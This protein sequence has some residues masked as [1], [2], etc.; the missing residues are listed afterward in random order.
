LS[1]D[2]GNT[3]QSMNVSQTDTVGIVGGKLTLSCML[4]RVALH[5]SYNSLPNAQI[6]PTLLSQVEKLGER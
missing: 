4:L 6:S 5:P 2:P 1:G 3:E